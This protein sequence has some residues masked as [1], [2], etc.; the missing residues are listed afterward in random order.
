MRAAIPAIG[1]ADISNECVMLVTELPHSSLQ[2]LVSDVKMS[3]AV[4]NTLPFL[5]VVLAG[6]F[7]DKAQ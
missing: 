7:G 2:G 1:H 3:S 5:E 4:R 6:L